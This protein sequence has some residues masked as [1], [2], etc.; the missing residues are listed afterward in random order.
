MAEEQVK[1]V[2]L[3]KSQQ[4]GRVR[5]RDTMPELLVR[6]LLHER[7]VRYRLQR[8]DL[9]GKPDIYV[10]RLR[11]AIYVNGCFWHSHNCPRGRAPKSNVGFWS[12]KLSR[13]VQRDR[14]TLNSI[15][16]LHLDAI[17]LWECE[18]ESFAFQCDAIAEQYRAA[19]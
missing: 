9:P 16:N 5:T 15:R 13:N 14:E 4:M 6:K 10:P 11:I 1:E 17:V 12:E 18:R 19:E 3:T 2:I 8:R 7:G